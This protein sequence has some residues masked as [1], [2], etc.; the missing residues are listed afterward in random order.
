MAKQ[1]KY[2]VDL[3]DGSSHLCATFAEAQAVERQH[4]RQNPDWAAIRAKAAEGARATGKAL[5]KAGRKTA[6]GIKA[7]APGVGQAL[8]HSWE[9]AKAGFKA[10]KEQNPPKGVSEQELEKAFQDESKRAKTVRDAFRAGAYVVE[11]TGEVVAPNAKAQRLLDTARALYE[12]HKRKYPWYRGDIQQNPGP[13]EHKRRAGQRYTAAVRSGDPL[14]AARLAFQAESDFDD[15]GDRRGA[16]DAHAYAL[17]ELKASRR[18]PPKPLVRRKPGRNPGTAGCYAQN[19]LTYKAPKGKLAVLIGAGLT[20]WSPH[21]ANTYIAP[22]LVPVA[23]LEA[24]GKA[25][26]DFINRTGIGGESWSAGVLGP[27]GV[28]ISG[29]VFDDKGQPVSRIAYNGRAF[30]ITPADRARLG[31]GD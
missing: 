23:T 5:A 21:L 25:V 6:A 27:S 24:A 3:P 20:P 2:R 18:N 16:E 7:A 29:M 17:G 28:S 9:G 26:R 14:D 13:E 8:K 31:M 1:A 12:S 22:R 19:P 10:A 11:S 4:A 15:A 30:D